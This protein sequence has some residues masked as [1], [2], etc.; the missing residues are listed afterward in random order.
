MSVESG[1]FEVLA[2]AGDMSLGGDD[3]DAAVAAQLLAEAGE[4]PCAPAGGAAV[5]HGALA[6]AR[7]VRERLSTERVTGWA[8]V[9][10][11]GSR[12]EGELRREALEA[13]ESRR[14]WRAPPPPAGRRC[15]TPGWSGWTAW[16]WCCSD[17][18]VFP[19]NL[20]NS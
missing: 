10:P 1:V 7:A 14:W 4:D 19:S 11:D 6:L 12:R 3:L 18:I 2:T 5:L 16:C 9:L 17:S 13:L 15:A 8:L 20:G